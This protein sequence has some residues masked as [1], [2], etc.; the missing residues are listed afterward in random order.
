MMR[1]KKGSGERQ[2]EGGNEKKKILDGEKLLNI[3]NRH[4]P[5]KITSYL[6]GGLS[7]TGG[8]HTHIKTLLINKHI[9]FSKH[10]K[11]FY[12]LHFYLI[13]FLSLNKAKEKVI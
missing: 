3:F 6:K 10:A 2:T 7:N 13:W 8:Q 11:L 1:Q 5:S 4:R 9:N 12:R